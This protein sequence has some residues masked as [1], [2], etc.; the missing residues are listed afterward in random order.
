MENREKVAFIRLD[1]N[2]IFRNST[3]CRNQ[4]EGFDRVDFKYR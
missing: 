4:D 1:A 3:L 2:R